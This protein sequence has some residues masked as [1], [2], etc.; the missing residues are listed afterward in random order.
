[1]ERWRTERQQLPE[2]RRICPARRRCRCLCRPRRIA[3]PV[4]NITVVTP[5]AG[6]LHTDGD[7]GGS[8]P[9][10]NDGCGNLTLDSTGLRDRSGT[11]RHQSLLGP[12]TDP[13]LPDP[14]HHRHVTPWPAVLTI[15]PIH[16]AAGRGAIA[17]FKEHLQP[18]AA[19]RR[20]GDGRDHDRGLA[21][22]RRH[23]RDARRADGAGRVHHRCEAKTLFGCPGAPAS[24]R[25]AMPSCFSAMPARRFAR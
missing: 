18:C 13:E 20:A 7:A 4:Y 17:G 22:G 1:M 15:D 14:W 11:A 21:G 25:S 2:S 12:L 19:A 23:A 8:G 6:D 24:F 10:A 16:R 9:M 3:A 5:D